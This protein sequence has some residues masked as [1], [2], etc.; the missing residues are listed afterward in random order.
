MTAEKILIYINVTGPSVTFQTDPH[1]SLDAFI[2]GY[3]AIAEGI[4]DAALVGVAS[5][6]ADPKFS[7]NLMELNFLS[8]DGI[9][10]AF[11]QNGNAFR[12]RR[13]IPQI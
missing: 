4:V 10:R 5:Q 12:I 7:L 11:D 1:G 6:V 3:N 9:C 13:R 8:P 2:H